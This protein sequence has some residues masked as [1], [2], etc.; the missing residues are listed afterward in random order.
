MLEGQRMDGLARTGGDTVPLQRWSLT[1]GTDTRTGRQTD[2]QTEQSSRGD[3]EKADGEGERRGVRRWMA[4]EVRT[5]ETE[6]GT[7]G[8]SRSAE[9]GELEHRPQGVQECGVR[10]CGVRACRKRGS[11]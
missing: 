1:E 4:G 11:Y 5:L 10:G 8:Q 3:Q 9:G 7:V 2:L 6:R